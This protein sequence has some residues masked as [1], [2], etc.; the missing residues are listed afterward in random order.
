MSEQA[1]QKKDNGTLE[2]IAIILGFVMLIPSFVFFAST[3]SDK[4]TRIGENAG[5]F[6][7]PGGGAT[8][9]VSCGE[10]TSV[11]A[12]MMPWVKDAAQ[13]WIGGDE[14]A[15]IALIDIES[16]WNPKAANS[17]SRAAGL[18]QFM[19][20]TARGMPEFR[21]G[22]DGK[23]RTWPSGGKITDD[24]PASDPDDVRF[25]PER[26]VYAVAH[27]MNIGKF[28]AERSLREMY[29]IH[30]HT[31]RNAEQ[32]A[33]ASAGA[34]K[35]LR[36]YS[37]IKDK[38]CEE[39]A[40]ASSGGGGGSGEVTG[41]KSC[42]VASGNASWGDTTKANPHRPTYPG[43]EGLDIMGNR[44]TEIYSVT[45]GKVARVGWSGGWRIFIQDKDGRYWFYQHMI[46]GEYLVRQGQEVKAGQLIGHMSDTG[47]E[48]RP[49]HL[50]LGIAKSQNVYTYGSRLNWADWYYPY[51]Y[52]S[53]IPC[54][55]RTLK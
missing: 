52:L 53:D 39:T 27:N 23:G 7:A 16:S 4:N 21:G 55:S 48:T 22:S 14:A 44:G 17:A 11:P 36:R 54:L 20:S 49:V 15:L 29:M 25:D 40:I 51:D 1:P 2:L 43:H 10:G 3:T 37:E 19:P 28:P 12:A 50:H 8:S 45:D 33:A 26:S 42:P 31:Y 38:H 5:S 13:K 30:Y 34:D 41:G 6:N 46:R 35:L 32:E 47:A 18:G 9:T 24:K